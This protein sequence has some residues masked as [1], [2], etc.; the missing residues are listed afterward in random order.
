MFYINV[1]LMKESVTQKGNCKEPI[2]TGMCICRKFSALIA[3]QLISHI[4]LSMA[5]SFQ[6]GL[7]YYDCVNIY[8]QLQMRILL[9]SG[10]DDILSLH[11]MIFIYDHFSLIAYKGILCDTPI[12]PAQECRQITSL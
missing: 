7:I 11:Q 9:H 10:G 5:H 2:Y 4:S 6:V 12:A 1:P 3:T 8:L